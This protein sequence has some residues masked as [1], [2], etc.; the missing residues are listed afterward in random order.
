MELKTADVERFVGGQL[1]V[2][3]PREGYIYRAEIG[4][5]VVLNEELPPAATLE[6]TFTW[7]ADGDGFPPSRWLRS[8]REYYSDSLMFFTATNIGP[9]PEGGG[10][11]ILL[12]AA[13]GEI[14][15]LYPPDGSKLDPSKIEEPDAVQA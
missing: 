10:D 15:T 6:I 12:K 5:I 13:S 1:E 4:T 3:N 2:Q 9:S 7:S 11:R 8:D 14:A